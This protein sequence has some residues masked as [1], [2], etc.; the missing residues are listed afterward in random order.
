MNEDGVS[1]PFRLS[2]HVVQGHLDPAISYLCSDKVMNDT[3]VKE[4]R[5]QTLLERHMFCYTLF[6]ID[7]IHLLYSLMTHNP[8][9]LFPLL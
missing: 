1:K 5:S 9:Y 7:K 6:R 4:K 8:T 2:L 3:E